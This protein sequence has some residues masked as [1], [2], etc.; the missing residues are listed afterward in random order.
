MIPNLWYSD[1]GG[2][3]GL[4]QELGAK[5]KKRAIS[6]CTKALPVAGEVLLHACVHTAIYQMNHAAI[7]NDKAHVYIK[8]LM[9]TEEILLLNTFQSVSNKSTA[10]LGRNAILY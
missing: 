3:V 9:N 10:K 6:K 8:D 2:T 4:L 7:V 5:Q 1:P